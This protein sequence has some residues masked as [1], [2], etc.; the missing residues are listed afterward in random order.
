MNYQRIGSRA[1]GLFRYADLYDG[2]DHLL[3]VLS[4]RFSDTYHRFA[5]ADITALV[6]TERSAWSPARLTV[7]ALSGIAAMIILLTAPGLHRLWFLLPGIF[8]FW[9]AAGAVR[10][11]RCK[12]M[13][14]TAVTRRHIEA[15][16]TMRAAAYVLPILSAKIAAAQGQWQPP[17]GVAPS[18]NAVPSPYESSG[19]GTG[20]PDILLQALFAT[21]G[22]HVVL[23]GIFYLLGQLDDAIGLSPVM[24]LGEIIMAILVLRRRA[25]LGAPLAALGLLIAILAVIDGAFAA[26]T[27]GKGFTDFFEAARRG[28][29]A[30]EIKYPLLNEQTA[31]RALWHS[32]LSLA[33]WLLFFL[34]RE[35]NS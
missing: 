12:L 3:Y 14:H 35:E 20:R 22:A 30:S 2:G 28:A 10:G 17:S 21:M 26:Y 16:R 31:V 8:L 7:A 4:S 9:A 19:E 1:P 18:P 27:V 23:L 24:L 34:R 5:W 29:P 11:P 13:L 33:G 25:S 15:V 6:L 32:A